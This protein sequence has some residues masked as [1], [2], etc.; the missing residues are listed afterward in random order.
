[1]ATSRLLLT[2]GSNGFAS[3]GM[4][5]SA[6][7]TS[8]HAMGAIGEKNEAD[9]ALPTFFIVNF[10]GYPLFYIIIYLLSNCYHL[11]FSKSTHH[12]EYQLSV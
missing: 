4:S 6:S 12:F 1:M 10:G 8:I 7:T 11:H 9:R 2:K 5:H 3:G